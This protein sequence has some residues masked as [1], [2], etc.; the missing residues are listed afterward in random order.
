[1]IY[2]TA[3]AHASG[4]HIVGMQHTN[5]DE[6]SSAT[7]AACD[8]PGTWQVTQRLSLPARLVLLP[9]HVVPK[10]RTC[11]RLHACKTCHECQRLAC[12]VTQD[13]S[14]SCQLTVISNAV[15]HC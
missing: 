3:A 13:G 14:S 8:V 15:L 7:S 6:T 12:A 4:A 1:V 10:E 11:Q 9:E 5:S 2:S